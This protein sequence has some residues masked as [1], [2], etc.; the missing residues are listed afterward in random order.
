[1]T[2][3]ERNWDSSRTILCSA[4][5]G[6]F[7]PEKRPAALIEALAGLP[8]RFKGLFVGWGPLREQLMELANRHIP[9]RYAFA[10]AE[11]HLGD[12]YHAMECFCLP[13]ASQVTMAAGVRFALCSIN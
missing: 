13:S 2:R 1:V 7:S 11:G 12:Y 6:R 5:S 8:E 9:G 10:E 3:C 4:L